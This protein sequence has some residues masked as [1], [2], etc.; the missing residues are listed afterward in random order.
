MRLRHCRPKALRQGMGKP[1]A[2][3]PGFGGLTKWQRVVRRTLRRC[4]CPDIVAEGGAANAAPLHLSRCVSE[5]PWAGRTISSLL[6]T[7]TV[8]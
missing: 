6:G 4:I 5:P 3:A 7:R 1:T 2:P 8:F